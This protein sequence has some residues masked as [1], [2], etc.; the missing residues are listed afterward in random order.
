MG[1]SGGGGDTTVHFAPYLEYAHQ[2]MLNNAGSVWLSS[3]IAAEINALFDASPYDPTDTVSADDGFLGTGYTIEQYPSLFD[4]YGKFMAGLDIEV[5]WT[6]LYNASVSGTE[7]SDAIAAQSDI[8]QDEI[9]TKVLPNLL[10]GYR[11]IGAVISTAFT[12]SK[13]LVVAAKVKTLADSESKLRLHMFDMAQARTQDHLNW[14]KSVIQMYADMMKLYYSAK[15]DDEARKMEWEVKDTLWN[16]SLFD[17]ARAFLGAINGAPAAK[18]ELQPS[19]A[20]KAVSMAMAGAGAGAQISSSLGYSG[21]SGAAIGGVLGLA[22]S[23]A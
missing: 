11:D 23:F 13:A 9:D 20:T 22:A 19:Q 8:L 7:I 5:L 1:K 6:Q 16:V 12:T 17:Y 4:M 10:A 2:N 14:N 3:S 21:G 18:N 15:F